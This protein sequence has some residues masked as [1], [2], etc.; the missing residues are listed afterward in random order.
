MNENLLKKTADF[1]VGD[2]VIYNGKAKMV[3]TTDSMSAYM[4]AMDLFGDSHLVYKGS[5]RHTGR[6]FPQ[7]GEV[8]R[9]MRSG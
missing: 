3:V 2:E 8:I 4:K 6:N 1:K 7:I 5:C 9:A